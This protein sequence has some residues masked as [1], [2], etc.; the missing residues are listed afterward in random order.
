[1]TVA[2]I[3]ATP[4]EVPGFDR[5]YPRADL[6]KVAG[7]FDYLVVISP[8]TEETRSLV[9]AEVLRAM[10]P[11]ARLVNVGRGAVI[12]EN[13][14]IQALREEWIGGAAL[15]AFIQEPLPA[16]HPFWSMNNVYLTPHIAGRHDGMV[17]QVLDIFQTNLH[18]Y[19]N[20]DFQ[21][22]INLTNRAALQTRAGTVPH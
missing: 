13:A 6:V 3:S 22:M 20:G 1:M 11:T 10:K 5:I 8:L 15:D 9:N 14:L 17:S 12:D 4:R 16:D 18:Y 21:S 19:L 7:E 2:G